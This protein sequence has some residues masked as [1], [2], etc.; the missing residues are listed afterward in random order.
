MILGVDIGGTKTMFVLYDHESFKVLDTIRSSQENLNILSDK[1]NKIVESYNIKAIGIGIAGW[2]RN[3]IL[4]KTPNIKDGSIRLNLTVPYILENDANCFAYGVYNILA[5]KDESNIRNIVGITV[6][7]GIGCGIVIDGKIYRGKG[8]AGELA[9]ITVEGEKNCSCGG[10]GHLESYFSGWSL[11]ERFKKPVKEVM[12]ENIE[13]FY[14]SREFDIF[15]KS[16]AN[17]VMIIDP[18]VIVF[19]GS[20]GMRFNKKIV[21]ERL[22]SYILPEFDTKVI[23]FIDEDVVAKGA[24]FLAKEAILSSD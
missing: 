10:K 5:K 11:E 22:K 23:L 13:G 18:D 14:E 20:I 6:G 16:I 21:E 15:V 7:T 12:E 2:V 4:L 24:I 17:L 1:I 19:G 8:L 9:H 3:G